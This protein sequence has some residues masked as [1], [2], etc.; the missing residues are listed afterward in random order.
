M[1]NHDHGKSC[2]CYSP[3]I[4]ISFRVTQM[5]SLC[6]HDDAVKRPLPDL[7][8]SRKAWV[9]PLLSPVWFF[10]CAFFCHRCSCGTFRRP[11]RVN[12]L[13]NQ[14]PF[15]T[16]TENWHSANN[17]LSKQSL[18]ASNN[19]NDCAI[20]LHVSVPPDNLI[21]A[22][23]RFLYPTCHDRQFDI[24]P[25]SRIMCMRSH[26]QWSTDHVY[27]I[28]SSTCSLCSPTL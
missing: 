15:V 13:L 8:R 19:N 1:N 24:T 14:V 16:A 9:V 7:L 2:L 18:S 20:P 22:I 12:W 3:L 25:V 4:H 21:H 23:S 5:V 11:R 27:M 10:P 17:L 6:W 26:L 28:E